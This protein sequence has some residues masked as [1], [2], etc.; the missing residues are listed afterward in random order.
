MKAIVIT[1]KGG[2]EV[3]EVRDVATPEPRGDQLRVRVR[4]AG[5]NRADLLQC[6]GVYPAPPGSPAD[7]PGLEYAGEIDALGPDVVGPIK[8]GDRVF[9]I[10][11]G[12]GLAEYLLTHERLVALIPSNLDFVQAAAV[13]EAFITAARCARHAGPGLTGRA[14]LDSC[15]WQRRGHRGRAACPCDG[16][17]SLGDVA[18]GREA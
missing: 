1:G 12:G 5:L 4:A 7:I 9:G 18:D 6:K 14:G 11:G 8:P 10:V 3:L 16:L 17:R 2:P 15:G 13:P